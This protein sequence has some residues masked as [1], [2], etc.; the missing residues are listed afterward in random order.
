MWSKDKGH[1]T[2]SASA[3]PVSI[4]ANLPDNITIENATTENITTEKPKRKARE[5]RSKP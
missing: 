2:Y 3:P 1:W 4:I 5:R